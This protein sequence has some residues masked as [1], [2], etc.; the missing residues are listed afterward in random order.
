MRKQILKTTIAA[1]AAVMAIWLLRVN[2]QENKRNHGNPMIATNWLGCIV[3]GGQ[4]SMDAIGH[5]LYPQCAQQFQ[6]GLRSDGVVVWR[7]AK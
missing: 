1:L 3:V 5:G 6:L 4:D 7:L 2:A